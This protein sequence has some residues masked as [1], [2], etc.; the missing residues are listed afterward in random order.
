MSSA[1]R[2]A[3][4]RSHP[5]AL[6]ALAAA[7]IGAGY[8]AWSMVVGRPV[9]TYRAVRGD[10]VQS[11]VVNGQ[12]VTPQRASIAAEVTA[13]VER[14]PVAEGDT[15]RRD[16]VLI[17]L[18]RSDERAAVVQARAALTQ[19][20]AKIRQIDKY[21]LPAAEQTL[22]QAE[23]NFTQARLAYQRT[24]DLV[25]KE[26]R[27]SGTTRRCAAQPRRCRKP[28]ALGA[29]CGGQPTVLAAAIACW[30]KRAAPRREAAV[31][32]AQ[33]KLDAT[34]IHAPA[35]GVLIGRSVE[36]GDVAQ[37]GKELMVLAPAGETQIVVNIDEKNL[38]KLAVG[39]KALVS[40]D[41]YPA[42]SFRGRGLLRQSRRRSGARRE[43]RSSCA[44]P[45]PPAYLRQD[46]TVSVD[47]AVGRR[48]ERADR[49]GR[50]VRDAAARIRGCSS[51]AAGGPS[52]S[53][54]RWACAAT[55][56]SRV[57]G[58]VAENEA[59]VPRPT[60]SS[61]PAQRV[62]PIAIPVTRR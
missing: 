18:D 22:R 41:A 59:L 16:Q 13:R 24:S 27:L 46:M 56:P 11:V 25:A 37:A 52:V 2:L 50:R 62:R 6:I 55:P 12:V 54:S 1:S 58:G 29:A 42:Q 20:E 38:G 60:P 14:V 21:T 49:A 23:A 32:V 51:C 43:S 61:R 45:S 15:V 8:I 19:A 30:R 3:S 31:A 35:D 7:A 44:C 5:V 47:I 10:L 4:P 33:A 57:T 39:Q 48:S 53:R 17:E 40:A 36:P 26:F 9:E 28:A 34:V